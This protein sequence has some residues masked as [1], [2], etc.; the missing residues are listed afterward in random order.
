MADDKDVKD[1]GDIDNWLADL[2]GDEPDQTASVAVSGSDGDEL[3]QADIDQ[4]LS[5]GGA[6]ESGAQE[7]SVELDQDDIDSLFGDGPQGEVPEPSV[8]AEAFPGEQ[9]TEPEAPQEEIGDEFED[10]FAEEFEEE[11]PADQ[12]QTEPDEPEA[13]VEAAGDEK[14]PEEAASSAPASPPAGDGGEAVPAEAGG[15]K[16]KDPFDFDDG[17]FDIEGFDF[18]DDIPDIPDENMLESSREGKRETAEEE[19]IFADTPSDTGAPVTGEAGEAEET[20]AGEDWKKRFAG[21]LPASFDKSAINKSTIGASLFSLLLLVGAAYW[22]LGRDEE[23]ELAIPP[24]V[25]E[26]LVEALEPER[27]EPVLPPVAK[28]ERFRMEQ[29]GAAVSLQLRAEAADGAPLAYE[30]VTPPRHGR[31]SGEPPRITY[32]P[33]PDFPGEDSFVFR[34]TDGRLASEPARVAIVGPSL[35]AKEDEKVLPEEVEEVL[36]LA[37]EQPLIRVRDLQL[38]TSSTKPLKID[39][40]AIWRRDNPVPFAGVRVEIMEQDLRGRLH[41]PDPAH[42]LYEPDPYFQGEESLV[43][44]FHY[45]GQRSKPRRLTMQVE[46]G[47]PPPTIRLAPLAAAYPVGE[48]VILDAR[49]TLAVQPQELHFQWRQLSGTTVHLESLVDNDALVRFVAPSAFAHLASPKVVLEVTAIDRHTGLQESK[50]VAI[51]TSSRRQSALWQ[52]EPAAE[53]PRNSPL[54]GY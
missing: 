29:P 47:N 4:L 45:A 3:D 5:G 7:D 37:P 54:W 51:G 43:Y 52:G 44:R 33:N 11:A 26:K 18:D 1:F 23:P 10:L 38:S 19:D 20:A 34:A 53:R 9:D 25:R 39:W 41:R 17:E 49:E 14:P 8:A 24:Q 22:L 16:E 30:I 50:T 36:T 27:P 21:W 6:E 32:L 28:A 35:R 15:E 42:H 48:T 40:A 31:L 12:P 13:A 2:D 46:S